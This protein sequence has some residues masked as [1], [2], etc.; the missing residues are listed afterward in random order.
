MEDDMSLHYCS[1]CGEFH[2][3][4]SSCPKTP[5]DDLFPKLTYHCPIC[6]KEHS[7]GEPCPKKFEKLHSSLLSSPKELLSSRDRSSDFSLTPLTYP[8]VCGERHPLGESCSK[9]YRCWMCGKGHLVGQRCPEE[10]FIIY[11]T[12]G[13]IPW[14]SEPWYSSYA[15]HRD[16]L[17]HI[18]W[19]GPL[20]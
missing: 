12:P 6:G 3:P 9:V 18:K 4:L 19:I 1:R 5:K 14:R 7:L 11:M 17:G 8:C 2:S 15:I 16:L 10:P 20:Y 13:A